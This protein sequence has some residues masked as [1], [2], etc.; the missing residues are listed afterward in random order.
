MIE[1]S[2]LETKLRKVNQ[3]RRLTMALYLYR[4]PAYST[5][6]DIMESYKNYP[7]QIRT[8]VHNRFNKNMVKLHVE[9][10][11]SFAFY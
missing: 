1:L 11:H 4:D 9:I 8:P 2:G 7:N 6:E 10:E 3:E 5:I